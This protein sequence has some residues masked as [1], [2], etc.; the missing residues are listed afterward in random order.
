MRNI[1]DKERDKLS[2]EIAG[3]ESSGNLMRRAV[4]IRLRHQ[5]HSLACFPTLW[6]SDEIRAC[7][8]DLRSWMDPGERAARTSDADSGPTIVMLQ[9]FCVSLAVICHNCRPDLA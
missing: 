4:R 6:R 8:R 1:S 9:D 2:A 5:P 7:A 3:L